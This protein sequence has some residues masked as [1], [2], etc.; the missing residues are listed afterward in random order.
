MSLIIKAVGA[1]ED[2]KATFENVGYLVIATMMAMI[3]HYFFVYVGCFAFFT[4]S[5]PFTYLKHILPAQT[6]AFAC[7][8][9]AA[10]VRELHTAVHYEN[11]PRLCT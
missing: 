1:Q 9:S 4:K 6:M 2:L 5:N 7:A 11:V 3:M 8:S 10:T